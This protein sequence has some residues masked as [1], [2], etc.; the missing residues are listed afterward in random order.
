MNNFRLELNSVE[1]LSELEIKILK[2]EIN[3]LPP[4][5]KD[6]IDIQ[7][8]YLYD[9]G[10][11]VESKII[12][13]NSTN[14]T[15]F[16]E[17]LNFILIDNEEKILGQQ[18][19]GLDFLGEIPAY[20][21]TPATISLDKIKFN[22][23]NKNLSECKIIIYDK[24]KG[25]YSQKIILGYLDDSL[26]EVNK[27]LFEKLVDEFPPMKLNTFEI[28][29]PRVIIAEGKVSVPVLVFSGY[30]QEFTIQ[31]LKIRFQDNLNLVKA[32]KEIKE[33]PVKVQPFT[34]NVY[35]FIFEP[36]EIYCDIEDLRIC[37]VSISN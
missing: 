34:A 3:D 35:N 22:L 18:L 31:N 5:D 13:R 24:L 4:L 19:I 29:Y 7:T 28:K 36:E 1:E 37:R 16:L 33:L 21:Y 23:D 17:K 26:D 25:M 30:T 14:R 12:I 9:I 20:S 2:E 10:E 6:R 15:V 32:Y 11:V 27:R 8:L